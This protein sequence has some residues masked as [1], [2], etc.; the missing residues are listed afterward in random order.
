MNIDE[1]NNKESNKRM[2]KILNLINSIIRIFIKSKFC[3]IVLC[4]I[5][6]LDLH[7]G[8]FYIVEVPGGFQPNKIYSECRE[9]IG[10]KLKQ[11]LKEASKRTVNRKIKRIE[12]H[13]CQDLGRS[14][15]CYVDYPRGNV[16]KTSFFS[17]WF[18]EDLYHC[19][20]QL[21]LLKLMD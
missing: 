11:Q 14:F 7:A 21:A 15:N 6:N 2:N 12:E 16:E 10:G 4:F 8:D 20:R 13:E 17:V 5:L 19:I 18:E 3:C 9:D 1:F